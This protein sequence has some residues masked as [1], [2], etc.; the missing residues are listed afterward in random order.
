MR[1]IW[2]GRALGDLRRIQLYVA[3]DDPAAA[4]R[5]VARLIARAEAVTDLPYSG[6][7][8]PEIGREDVREVIVKGYRIVYAVSEASVRILTIFEGHR[9]LPSDASLDEPGD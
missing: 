7:K 8:V 9:R 5:W 2:E 3:Q 4:A 1:V 6:R